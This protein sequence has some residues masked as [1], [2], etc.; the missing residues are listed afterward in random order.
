MLLIHFVLNNWSTKKVDLWSLCGGSECTRRT[1]PPL[2][3]GLYSAFFFFASLTGKGV[4]LQ[5][6]PIHIFKTTHT[7]ATKLSYN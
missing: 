2:P 5:K 7:S 3:T 4:G 6:P 1:P